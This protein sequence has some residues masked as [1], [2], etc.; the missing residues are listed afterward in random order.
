[1]ILIEKKSCYV[2]LFTHGIVLML[3]LIVEG[4]S[5][6]ELEKDESATAMKKL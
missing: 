6:K 1:M 5:T 4:S 3:M 2:A